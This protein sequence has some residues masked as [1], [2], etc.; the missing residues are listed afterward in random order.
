MH[1]KVFWLGAVAAEA[2]CP[3]TESERLL[4]ILERKDFARRERQSAVAG[5]TQY[6]FQHVLLRDVAGYGQI[7]RSARAQKHRRAGEWIEGLGRPDDHAGTAARVPLWAGAPTCAGGRNRRRPEPRGAHARGSSRSRRA[8]DGAVG[9]RIGRRLLRRR[10]R[11]SRPRD[12]S[13]WPRLLEAPTAPVRS[14][15]STAP[16]WIYC[17]RHSR[18]FE[19]RETPKAK[20]ERRRLPRASRGSPATIRDGPVHRLC[21]RRRSR[22]A[23]LWAGPKR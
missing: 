5:D 10:D 7:P 6:S 1:G 13:A 21:P 4:R 22:P 11:P 19:R 23:R 18:G 12:H 16:V 8:S 3:L 17:P 9:V 20:P 14:C 15:R 2:A